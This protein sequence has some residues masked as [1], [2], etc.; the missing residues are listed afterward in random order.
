MSQHSGAA[1]GGWVSTGGGGGP[2]VGRQGRRIQQLREQPLQLRLHR[3]PHEF[4]LVLRLQHGL[5]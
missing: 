4:A 2:V 1:S 3:L 5:A